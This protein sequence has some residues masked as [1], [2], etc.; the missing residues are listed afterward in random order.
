MEPA[1]IVNRWPHRPPHCTADGSRVY[2]INNAQRAYCEAGRHR[3]IYVAAEPLVRGS[4]PG[5]RQVDG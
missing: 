3:W 5:W 2:F 4:R 1:D